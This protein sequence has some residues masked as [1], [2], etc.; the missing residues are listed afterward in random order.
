MRS[1]ENLK[2]RVA[3]C[4]TGQVR[5]YSDECIERLNNVL[6]FDT[7]YGICINIKNNNL[8][9]K[10]NI[11]ELF[12]PEPE[13]H[14]YLVD[15]KYVPNCPTFKRYRDHKIWTK[16]GLYDASN[17]QYLEVL[18]HF[19]LIQ[20]L[21][22]KYDIIIKCRF[23]VFLSDKID[24]INFINHTIETD[25]TIGMSNLDKFTDESRPL[26]MG[27]FRSDVNKDIYLYNHLIFHKRNN[28]ADVPKLIK[29][30]RLLPAEY[31]Y[32]QAYAE[33][34]G[35]GFIN[36]QGGMVIA[37]HKFGKIYNFS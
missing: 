29:E 1:F 7:Y 5:D 8:K 30:K 21:N 33:K 31:G 28:T 12:Q 27:N 23:D 36:F 26:T 18:N 16:E 14:P 4:V 34:N 10:K 13:Y 11:I 19:N 24:F 25:K 2:N 9:N 35:K 15:E 32:Y 3:V 20:K 37:R 17:K 6:P 22:S